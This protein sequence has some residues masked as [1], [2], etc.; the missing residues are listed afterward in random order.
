MHYFVQN[1]VFSWKNATF[2]AIYLAKYNIFAKK[3]GAKGII[4]E[5]NDYYEAKHC[6]LHRKRSTTSIERKS[7]QL[8]TV[9]YK[10][11]TTT[12]GPAVGRLGRSMKNSPLKM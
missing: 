4:K 7:V 11:Q 9:S 10:P 8:L 2:K 5:H 1:T 6:L 12:K 3:I